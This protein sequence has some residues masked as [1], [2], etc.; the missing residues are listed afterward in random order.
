NKNGI[1]DGADSEIIFDNLRAQIKLGHSESIQLILQAMSD[2]NVKSGDTADIKIGAVVLED[3]SVAMVNATDKLIIVEPEINFTTPKFDDNK[4]TS[5]LDDNVYIEA[6]YAQ[7]NFQL[8]KPDQVWVTIT[9]LLTGDKYS[10]KGIE[11]GNSTG[12]YQLS[13]PTQNNANAINDKIIQTLKNDT[14]TASLDACIAPSVGTGT[15]QLPSDADLT[16]RIDN[17]AN[18]ITIIDDSAS[19]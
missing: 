8:D 12:K 2:S 9:S 15:E 13:A 19:L 1:I 4:T 14:L 7:C 6:S 5:Q 3:P 10:L 17:L 11:T 16:V 18:Q